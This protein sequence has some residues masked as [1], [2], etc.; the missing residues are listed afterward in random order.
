MVSGAPL[1]FGMTLGAFGRVS[2]IVQILVAVY[3]IYSNIAKLIGKIKI[4]VYNTPRL[5]VRGGSTVLI[6]VMVGLILLN[7]YIFKLGNPLD[8]KNLFSLLYGWGILYWALFA[9]FFSTITFKQLYYSWY[10]VKYDERFYKDLNF[11][12]EE[13]YGKRK[14]KKIQRTE[15][16]KKSK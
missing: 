15:A 8:Q 2:F 14:A 12:D 5:R 6:V 3:L 7:Q 1:L 10:L 13:W 9:I 11:T 16:K 4:E